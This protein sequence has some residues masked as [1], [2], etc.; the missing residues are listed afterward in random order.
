MSAAPAIVGDEADA[1]ERVVERYRQPPAGAGQ[2]FRDG[3]RAGEVKAVW[4]RPGGERIVASPLD[5]TDD[6]FDDALIGPTML[7]NDGQPG[8]FSIAIARST[9][10][11]N[12]LSLDRFCDAVFGRPDERV[13]AAPDKDRGGR[14][15]RHDWAGVEAQAFARVWHHGIPKSKNELAGE[16]F[17]WLARTVLAPPDLRSVEKEV[18]KLWPKLIAMVEGPCALEPRE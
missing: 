10:E 15:A 8:G 12:L 11:I 18:A 7:I 3:L 16:I 1:I 2:A 14:P 5:F 17:D 6:A 13:E 4:V 9:L